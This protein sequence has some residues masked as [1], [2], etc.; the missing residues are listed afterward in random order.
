MDLLKSL[1]NNLG[2]VVSKILLILLILLI[3]QQDTSMS[4]GSRKIVMFLTCAMFE[5]NKEIEIEI[6]KK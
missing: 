6:E 3:V 2:L 4:I 1:A 5:P